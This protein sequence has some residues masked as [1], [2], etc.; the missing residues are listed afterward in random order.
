[1]ANDREAVYKSKEQY[2]KLLED[3]V[4]K[5]SSLQQLHYTSNCFGGL[6]GDALKIGVSMLWPLRRRP[7]VSLPESYP[8]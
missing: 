1:M 7:S 5:L 8:G 4:A 3:H 6:D 2:Q